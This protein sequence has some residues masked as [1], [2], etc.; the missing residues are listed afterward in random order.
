[1]AGS[2]SQPFR[3]DS[4]S[5]SN[6][7][8]GSFSAAHSDSATLEVSDDIG[9]E[10]IGSS[11]ENPGEPARGA[12]GVKQSDTATATAPVDQQ[13][14]TNFQLRSWR[15]LLG[16]VRGVT[17][18]R[19][20]PGFLVSLILHTSLLL[21]LA[22][23]T[24]AGG[25]SGHAI[26]GIISSVNEA[27]AESE[28]EVTDSSL[29]SGVVTEEATSSA[30]QALMAA[31]ALE[32]I[33]AGSM[34]ESLRDI[35]NDQGAEGSVRAN[36]NESAAGELIKSTASSFNASLTSIS[37]DGRKPESRQRLALQGGGSADSEAAVE[38]A[39]EWLAAHQRPNG[40]WSL[41]HTKPECGAYCTH[42]GTP[43]RYEPAA[44]GLA[45]LAF[46][47]AGYTHRDGK[48]SSVVKN[49]V[50]YL[51][52]VMEMTPQGGS[53]LHSH[54]QGMYNQGIATFALCEAYQLSKDE[55]LRAPCQRAIQFIVNAQNDAGGWGYLPKRPGDL[56]ITGW[57]TM[58]LKS[59]DGAEIYIPAQTIARID[60]FLDS[61]TDKEKIFYGYTSPGKSETCTAIG[62]LLRLFRNWPH[63]DPRVLTG[64]NY[65]EQ[66]GISNHDI[67]RNYY[68]TL[69]LYHVGGPAFKQWNERMRD[70]LVQTQERKA[71][72]AGS[73]Y[74]DDKF[75]E[76][77]GRLYTTAMAAMTLEVYYRFSPIYLNSDRPFEY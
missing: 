34:G 39:L 50:Y 22:V 8:A 11:G 44:T 21:F 16:W 43:E 6:H 37:V 52:Q 51:L 20:T 66:Q 38:R 3:G 76:V 5:P 72:A 42:P 58:A 56:T 4:R 77:G 30:E 12:V 59:A 41:V 47:G 14:S 71:H 35:A 9:F 73:W 67:Y 24:V 53:F 18:S 74:F 64:V 17:V 26:I 55:A 57:Q 49:G 33:S 31:P 1:M 32:I 19:S 70:S 28:I 54:P 27:E 48:Y 63:S 46:L 60:D 68:A 65:L 7:A 62:L 45:L 15:R 10:A 40:S 61:Q 29:A 75:G 36:R 2:G 13:N 23:W 69:L 25:G